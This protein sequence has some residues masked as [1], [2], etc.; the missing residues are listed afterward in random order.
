MHIR[1]NETTKLYE[2][3]PGGGFVN[4]P[5]DAAQ[6][7]QGAFHIDR[8]PAI[9]YSKLSLS[10][11]DIPWAKIL[12]ADGGIGWAKVSKT[13]SSLGDLATRAVANLSDGSNV[14]LIN[15]T[16]TI[17]G[18]CWAFTNGF[19]ERGRTAKLGDWTAIAYSAGNFTT[20]NATTWTVEEADHVAYRYMQHGHTCR[21]RFQFQS[22]A[23]SAGNPTYL[24]AAGLPVASHGT[25]YQRGYCFVYFVEDDL[26]HKCLIQLAASS[27]TITFY[28]INNADQL[29]VW[30][31]KTISLI[32]EIEYETE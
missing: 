1:Y 24:I 32:G 29:S 8:I 26:Y 21:I 14:P 10:D 18:D 15:G 23:I 16:P 25:G 11:G 19:K 22:T 4:L 5:L 27:S 20:N 6:I 3:D 28:Y 17:S 12:V 31:Q 2:Y 9:P 7:S 13:S 30:P